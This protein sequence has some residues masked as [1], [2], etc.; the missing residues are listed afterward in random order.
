MPTIALSGLESALYEACANVIEHG[1][2][3]DPAGRLELSWIAG[4]STPAQG[5]TTHVDTVPPGGQRSKSD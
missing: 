4:D 2:G 5:D 1:Y 3:L